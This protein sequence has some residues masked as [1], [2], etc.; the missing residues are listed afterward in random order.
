M[1]TYLNFKSIGQR[2]S[3]TVDVGSRLT[4]VASLW[5]FDD[6]ISAI[7]TNTEKVFLSMS[8]KARKIVTTVSNKIWL[9]SIFYVLQYISLI[10]TPALVQTFHGLTTR[11]TMMAATVSHLFAKSIIKFKFSHLLRLTIVGKR[12]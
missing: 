6:K 5:W 3:G 11:S 7:Y 2:K 4:S 10:L 1:F 12:K 8:T 9:W